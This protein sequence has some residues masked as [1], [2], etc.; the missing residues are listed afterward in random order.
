MTTDILTMNI[1]KCQSAETN[2]EIRI[3]SNIITPRDAVPHRMVCHDSSATN[4]TQKVK[5][6]ISSLKFKAIIMFSAQLNVL[7]KS[8]V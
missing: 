6:L 4:S 1:T 2:L 5:S 7:K 3:P 8:K